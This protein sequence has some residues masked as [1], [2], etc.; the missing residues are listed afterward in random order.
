MSDTMMD[1]DLQ[2]RV[3]KYPVIELFGPTVQG[4]GI[5]IGHVTHFLRLGGCG[6]KCLWCDSMHAVDPAQIK[7]N[8]KM[9]T[10]EDIIQSINNM[11]S[12]PWLTLTG[13]DPCMH[14][15][16]ELVT[17]CTRNNLAVC[18]ETQG[19]F[20]PKWLYECDVV[21]LSPKPPSSGNVTDINRFIAE[22]VTLR[23]R[24]GVI[25]VKPVI[26]DQADLDYA[27]MLFTEM[28]ALPVAAPYD[29]FHFQVGSPL[30]SEVPRPDTEEWV[31]LSRD[32][33][34]KLL[35]TVKRE[36]IFQSYQW[37]VGRLMQHSHQFTHKVAITPQLHTLL[38]P[39]EDTGR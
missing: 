1:A 17:W 11:Q 13:G 36:M 27:L 6:Y 29:A 26:F 32:Q 24:G 4:E 28:E 35:G 14:D 39:L 12:A 25:C 9:M 16:T 38:W 18:V 30:T 19:E 23:N 3:R 34:D 5:Q 7:V 33:Q 37:L 15:L 31:E 20:W 21:T 8:R 2:Q 22:L 10:T